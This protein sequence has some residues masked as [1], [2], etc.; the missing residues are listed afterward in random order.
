MIA[1]SALLIQLALPYT[2]TWGSHSPLDIGA[3][4]AADLALEDCRCLLCDLCICG[5][6]LQLGSPALSCEVW[7]GISGSCENKYNDYCTVNEVTLQY[8]TKYYQD[9]RQPY[10]LGNSYAP[11]T[12]FIT[13]L[14]HYAIIII[15]PVWKVYDNYYIK[16]PSY[17]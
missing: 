17:R 13:N 15:T 8:V 16:L 6:V 12:L 2:P 5:L 4:E 7:K 3:R 1:S 14:R 9:G 11:A 10:A